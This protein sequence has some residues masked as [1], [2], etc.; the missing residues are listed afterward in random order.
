MPKLSGSMENGVIVSWEKEAG[1]IIKKGDVLYEVETDK[2]VIEVESPEEG[3]LKE[4]YYEEGDTVSVGE[5]IAEIEAN[6]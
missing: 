1:D 5:I 3:I 2:V 6:N 4:V